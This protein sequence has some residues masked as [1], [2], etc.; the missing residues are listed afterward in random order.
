MIVKEPKKF[1]NYYNTESWQLLKHAAHIRDRW[2]CIICGHHIEDSADIVIDGHHRFYYHH[3]PEFK[4]LEYPLESIA[5]LCRACHD[6]VTALNE[7]L[8]RNNF[9]E[10]E[11]NNDDWAEEM[12][13][14][15]FPGE[16]TKWDFNAITERQLT[17]VE[18]VT[19]VTVE[20]IT[21]AKPIGGLRKNGGPAIVYDA[22]WDQGKHALV[23][24]RDIDKAVTGRLKTGLKTEDAYITDT[25]SALVRNNHIGMELNHSKERVYLIPDL[26]AQALVQENDI[27]PQKRN[28]KDIF[29]SVAAVFII[30]ACAAV[31]YTVLT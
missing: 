9:G 16:T 30:V 31:T 26:E 14:K 3:R 2:T 25:L 24:R 20:D 23:P 10:V 8:Y 11:L 28:V 7:N 18:P 21:Q 5:T 12:R 29:I 13:V 27:P 17:L 22:I 19:P 1:I 6:K 4:G 15:L